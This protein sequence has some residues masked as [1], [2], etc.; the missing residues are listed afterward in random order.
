M[1]NL[2]YFFI[3]AGP[4]ETVKQKLRLARLEDN[5]LGSGNGAGQDKDLE[6]QPSQCF[7]YDQCTRDVLEAT[8]D[9]PL[10]RYAIP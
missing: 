9:C 3:K 6:N 7:L 10:T 8:V 1:F 4:T 2:F 5:E